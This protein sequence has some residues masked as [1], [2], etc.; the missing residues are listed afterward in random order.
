[1]IRRELI[2]QYYDSKSDYQRASQRKED[3]DALYSLVERNREDI[4][5]WLVEIIDRVNEVEELL[6][7]EKWK[8]SGPLFK[9]ICGEIL[10]GGK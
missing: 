5:D 4:K 10:K 7:T 6:L 1:M 2:E 9:D 8:Y 3:Y